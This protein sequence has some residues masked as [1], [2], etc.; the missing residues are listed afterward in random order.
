MIRGKDM[1]RSAVLERECFE[2][3]ARSSLEMTQ[4]LLERHRYRLAG[5]AECNRAAHDIGEILKLCCD[6][7]RE[8]S[9]TLHPRA[10]WYLGKVIAVICV[11]SAMFAYFGG[12]LV[13]IGFL[14]CLFGLT[15]GLAQYVFYW[16][17]F[18]PFFKSGK[19]C[20][21]VGTLEPAFATEQQVVLVGHHD[22]PFI[23]NFLERFQRIAFTRFLLGM[24]SFIWICFCSGLLSIRQVSMHEPQTMHGPLLWI[25][26]LGL[27]FAV[28]LFFMMS[29]TP[30]PG[31]GDNLNS[32]SM[33]AGVAKYFKEQRHGGSPLKH[34]R[35]I[36]L[37]TDGEEIGQRGAMEYVRRHRQDLLEVP[38]YVFNVDSVYYYKDLAVLT[39]DR[40][41]TCR[42]SKEMVSAISDVAARNSIRLRRKPIPFGG[43]GTD[44]AAFS[45][46]GINATTLIAQPT[47]FFSDDHRYH[48]STDV[49]EAIEIKAAQAVLQLAI[50]YIRG[51]D[52]RH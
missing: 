45:I 14:L 17:L 44:A 23:F 51:V 39:R 6:Q 2:N 37:S 27:A 30:S 35:L 10:L 9:F 47:G 8:E 18:D 52:D 31:A 34:T 19:G 16:R 50:E 1:K 26:I 7:C 15:Y 11:L 32:T 20:N 38:S 42:L 22:S 48:T 12:C 13:Y 40:N 28:P 43:G 36:V 3:T 46:A 25:T 33:N 4:G 49:V 29:G 41:N 21:V 5:S 24:T